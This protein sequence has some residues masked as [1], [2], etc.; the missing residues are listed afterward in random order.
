MAKSEARKKRLKLLRQDG[1]DVAEKRGTS[2][3]STHVRMTK[4]KKETIDKEYRKY[5]KHYEND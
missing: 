1:K 4:T 3:F 2:E 5:K